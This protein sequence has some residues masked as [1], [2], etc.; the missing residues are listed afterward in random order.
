MILTTNR[1]DTMDPAFNS[2]VHI[3]LHYPNLDAGTRRK[4]WVNSVAKSTGF[5]SKQRI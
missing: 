1:A 3:R 5:R 4:V 2:R